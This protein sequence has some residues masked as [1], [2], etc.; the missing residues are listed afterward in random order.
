[1]ADSAPTTTEGKSTRGFGCLILLLIGMAVLSVLGLSIAGMAGGLVPAD[2]IVEVSESVEP[3]ATQKL[4]V[5]EFSGVI[6]GMDAASARGGQARTLLRMLER[7]SSDESV[8]GILLRLNTPGGGVTA[9]DILHD[10][11]RRIRR[12]GKKVVVLMGDLCASGGVYLAV[13]A[14]K[15]WAHPTT[16][17]GSI[18]VLLGSYSLKQLLER[19]GILDQTV[20]SGANKQILSMSRELTEEQRAMLQEIVDSLHNRFVSLVAEGRKK[21]VDAVKPF[22]DGRLLTADYAKK[23]GLIDDVG[24]R[25]NAMDDLKAISGGGPFNVVR[26]AQEETLLEQLSVRASSSFG[27]GDQLME[28]LLSGPRAYY[29]YGSAAGASAGNQE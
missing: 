14:D 4:V 27:L 28:G 16:I 3:S 6:A 17:T 13:A 23:V 25:K 29:L 19:H 11:V 2:Q 7:A 22:S 15:I 10:A 8:A 24:Y 20:V 9:S 18:G 26:Y 5:M 1:M 21:K 12:K